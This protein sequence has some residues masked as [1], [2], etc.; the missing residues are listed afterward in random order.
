MGNSTGFAHNGQFSSIVGWKPEGLEFKVSF[1]VK[2][3]GEFIDFD[4]RGI[5]WDP[6][7]GLFTATPSAKPAAPGF[8]PWFDVLH[9]LSEKNHR[10]PDDSSGG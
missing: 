5:P 8:T 4:D 2:R 7:S 10:G 3:D 1:P 9:L 6:E